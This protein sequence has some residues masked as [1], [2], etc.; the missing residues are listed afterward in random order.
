MMRLLCQ[1]KYESLRKRNKRRA[2]TAQRRQLAFKKDALMKGRVSGFPRPA[3]LE[4]Y[5]TLGKTPR[6]PGLPMRTSIWTR[7]LDRPSL[8]P[9]HGSKKERDNSGS[10]EGLIN[11]EYGMISTR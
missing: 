4:K 8:R 3:D 7:T 2:Q 9:L 1:K 10:Q 11:S 5:V 6:S